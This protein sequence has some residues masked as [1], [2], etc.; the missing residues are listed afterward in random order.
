MKLY[1]GPLSMF[2]AKAEIAVAEKNVNCNIELVPYLRGK[3]YNPKHPEVLR[4]NP[5]GQVPILIDNDIEIY[6]STQI[7]EYLEH[8]YS[9]TPLWPSDPSI[10]ARARQLEHASDEVFFPHVRTLMQRSSAHTVEEF[11]TARQGINNYYN[12]MEKLL[13]GQEFLAGDYSYADIAFFMAHYFAVLIGRD[14]KPNHQ[15]LDA[16][17]RRILI[18]PAVH[19]VIQTMNIF[20]RSQKLTAPGFAD[21]GVSPFNFEASDLGPVEA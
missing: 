16:W 3:G 2:G 21:I 1:S 13:T 10:R 19:A 20:I 15:H 8:R 9:A 4:V 7:F 12:Q 17:R 11:Q 14:L 5:K 18:R 6:D